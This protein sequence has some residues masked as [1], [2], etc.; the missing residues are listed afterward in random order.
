MTTPTPERPR[1]AAIYERI[2]SDPT[3][4][5]AGVDR[6]D[7]DCRALAAHLGWDVIAVHRDN[8]V[9]A[10]SASVRRGYRNL[11]DDLRT[12]RADALI[13]W[14]PD[15]LYRRLPDLEELTRVAQ[16]RDILIRTVRAG[17]VDLNSASGVMTAEILASVSKH[18]IAHS[19]ERVTRAKA[20]A[21]AEGRYRG[22]P[23]PYG[24][25]ADGVTV[26][27]LLCPQCAAPDGFDPQ[28]ACRS[29]GAGAHNAPGSEAWHVEQAINAVI[30]GDSI[31]GATRAANAAG[32]RTA[33]R[34][35][36]QPDGTKSEPESR[37]WQPVDFRRMLLRAR[38]AGLVEQHGE[39][40]GP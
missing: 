29:C 20:Q 22:G 24:Y 5:A 14:H 28:R 11:L 7:A 35:Y 1:N 3:G 36:R 19:I 12:G 27:T 26:R 21:A 4:R 10:Y 2:S 13:A 40:T 34:R 39:I 18:E 33:G 15:R 25:E 17:A 38:N 16:E 31:R 8:D 30:A 9:S 6:Q 37:E 32:A 23:R